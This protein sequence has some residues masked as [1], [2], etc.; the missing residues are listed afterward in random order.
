[1]K[2]LHLSSGGLFGGIETFL[3][4]LARARETCPAMEPH[5]ALCA[6]GR[7]SEELRESGVTVNMLGPVRARK[8]ASVMRARRALGCL[9]DR[10]GYD[11]V[12]SH[13]SWTQALFGGV[14]RGAD[15]PFVFFLHN[16]V[17]GR[18]WLERWARRNRPDLVLANSQFTAS[19]IPSLY[20][21][22][23]SEVVRYPVAPGPTRSDADDRL[24]ARA[25]LDTAAT[26]VVL[27]QTSR[28]ESWKGHRLHLQ[29]LRGL[30][31]LDGWVS[32][33]VG[34]VQRPSEQA[35]LASLQ[36]EAAELGIADR[37]RWVG[38]RQDV[39]R[40]LAA[41]DIHCQP[42]LGAEPF[43]IVFIEAM[44]AAL[45]VVTTALG[46]ALEIVDESCGILTPPNDAGALAEALRELITDPERRRSLGTGGRA[47]AA[48]LCSPETQIPALHDALVRAVE[49]HG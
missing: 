36:R 27:I 1:M 46:G 18:H 34:G 41:A 8:P 28:M 24:K 43:G 10:E 4:T 29:G 48:A 45:P 23:A 3:L 44:Y 40:L 42:N 31:D 35:Y 7:L 37:V 14:V 22:V 25:E 16:D 30:R 47:R 19:S 13:S 9:L 32:W 11:V 17:T 12:V 26:D 33:Q 21:S 39:P 49:I 15:L 38:Q 5:F 20:P 2:A 6:E